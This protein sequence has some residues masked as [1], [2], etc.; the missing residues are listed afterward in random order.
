MT[1]EVRP[2][3]TTLTCLLCIS[4]AEFPCLQTYTLIAC[5]LATQPRLSTRWAPLDGW[6]SAPA[7]GPSLSTSPPTCASPSTPL[8]LALAITPPTWCSCRSAAL[9]LRL[10]PEGGHEKGTH[11]FALLFDLN[12]VPFLHRIDCTGLSR[13]LGLYRCFSA[14]HYSS[15]ASA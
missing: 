4:M 2:T 12:L 13:G 9:L 14:L 11:D 10:H 3:S 15:E 1:P 7:A 5:R 6:Q 8:Q